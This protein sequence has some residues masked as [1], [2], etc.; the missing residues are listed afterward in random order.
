[1]ASSFWLLKDLYCCSKSTYRPG[2]STDPIGGVPSKLP[3]PLI[4]CRVNGVVVRL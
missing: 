3:S 1:V 4:A 2:G